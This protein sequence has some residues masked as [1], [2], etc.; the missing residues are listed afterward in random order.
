M[1]PDFTLT[2]SRTGHSMTCCF[3]LTGSQTTMANSFQTESAEA[4]TR[5]LRQTTVAAFVHPMEFYMLWLQYQ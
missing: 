3:G 2:L 4:D 5:T 1:D